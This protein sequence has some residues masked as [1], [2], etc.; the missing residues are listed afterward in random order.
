MMFPMDQLVCALAH[1]RQALAAK[2]DEVERLIEQCEALEI[3][4]E[5]LEL[6]IE[7]AAL[8]SG[9][10]MPHPVVVVLCPVP[11][12]TIPCKSQVRIGADLSE[13]L[14]KVK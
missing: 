8:R 11:Y 5:L 1:R 7:T 13:Y 14:E 6:D 10:V 4:C 9:D 12:V 3:E 2:Q